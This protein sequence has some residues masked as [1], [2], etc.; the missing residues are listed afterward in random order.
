MIIFYLYV[1]GCFIYIILLLIGFYLNYCEM[2]KKKK[3]EF[4]VVIIY[5]IK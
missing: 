3:N 2:I 4:V 5:V 1:M